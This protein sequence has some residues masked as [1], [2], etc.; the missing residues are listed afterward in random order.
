V[1]NI[2]TPF[3][4]QV[5][6]F[7]DEQWI[8]N[9]RMVRGE[10]EELP[11]VRYIEFGIFC[12]NFCVYLRELWVSLR[13]YHINSHIFERRGYG[14]THRDRKTEA[15]VMSKSLNMIFEEKKIPHHG[16]DP[17]QYMDL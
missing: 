1:F 9:G 2:K 10:S 5:E 4:A 7:L 3:S 16:L 12:L 17:N 11:V 14:N 13:G 6:R 15:F 8:S